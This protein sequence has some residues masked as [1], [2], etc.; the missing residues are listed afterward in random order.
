MRESGWSTSL[1]VGLMGV[2]SQGVGSVGLMG[3]ISHGV[4]RSD[5]CY[6]PRPPQGVVRASGTALCGEALEKVPGKAPRRV[7][8]GK[9]LSLPLEALGGKALENAPG[10]DPW[11]E[12]P[13]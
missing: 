3:V 6:L 1:H 8:H 11:R 9:A 13:G 5:G 7:P 10:E 12:P 4:G 2:F